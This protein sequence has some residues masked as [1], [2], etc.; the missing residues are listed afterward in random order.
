[1]KKSKSNY[2]KKEKHRKFDY[3]R[4]KKRKK[5]FDNASNTDDSI[6]IAEDSSD[7][8][9]ILSISISLSVD[10]W[11]LNSLFSYHMCLHRGWFSTYHPIDG[12]VVFIKN[13]I[14]YKV[15]SIGT[16]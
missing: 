4:L 14:L 10:S 8:I 13:N 15:V 1:M 3:P 6:S 9:N 5:R 16:I 11:I 2:Y 7:S 12:G